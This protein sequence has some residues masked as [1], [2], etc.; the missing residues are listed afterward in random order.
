MFACRHVSQLDIPG[1]ASKLITDHFFGCSC[2]EY[3]VVISD[4]IPFIYKEILIITSCL[5]NRA[6]RICVTLNIQEG[7]YPKE[8]CCDWHLVVDIIIIT[9]G[10]DCVSKQWRLSEPNTRH[11]IQFLTCSYIVY[12]FMVLIVIY[13]EIEVYLNVWRINVWCRWAESIDGW[14]V[15]CVFRFETAACSNL[16]IWKFSYFL[17]RFNFKSA[18]SF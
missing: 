3:P 2:L 18:Y 8:I 10:C 6:S 9:D 5:H 14:R 13:M 16:R 1:R 7:E 17:A 4:H 12:Y 11:V 15:E